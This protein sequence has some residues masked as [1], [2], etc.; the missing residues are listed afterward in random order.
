MLVCS[1]HDGGLLQPDVCWENYTAEYKQSRRFLKCNED[2]F[3]IQVLDKS[4]RGEVLLDLV[5]TSVDEFIKEVKTGGNPGCSDHAL[6]EF[7]MLRN[8]GLKKSTVRTLNFLKVKFK[9]FKNLV[10]AIPWN[11]VLMDKRD[12]QSWPL[13][14]DVFLRAQELGVPLCKKASVEH[15]KQ[16]RL[17]KFCWSN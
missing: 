9:I 14:K 11:T 16:G 7:V 17:C 6:L 4:T 12:E 13:P 3:L 2:K 1:H 5:L 15:R 10:S 8:I